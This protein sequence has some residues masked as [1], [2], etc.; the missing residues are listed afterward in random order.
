MALYGHAENG[1]GKEILKNVSPMR[2][3]CGAATADGQ[4]EKPASRGVTMRRGETR[5]YCGARGERRSLRG[6]GAFV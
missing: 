3:Y 4:C 5:F 6:G 1:A 2:K